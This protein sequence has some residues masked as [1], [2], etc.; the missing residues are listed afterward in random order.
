LNLNFKKHDRRKERVWPSR[1]ERRQFSD[2][3]RHI[4]EQVKELE[5][6]ILSQVLDQ[7]KAFVAT[8]MGASDPV[9]SYKKIDLVVMDEATQC[10]EPMSWIPLLMAEKAVLAGDH[11]QLPPTIKSK[12][13]WDGGLN[14]TLFE[15]IYPLIGD[16]YKTLLRIQYRMHQKIMSYSSD[17]F[18]EGKLIADP[19]VKNHTLSDLEKV[20]VDDVTKE[21]LMFLDTAGRGFEEQLEN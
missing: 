15:R 5:R 14:L 8:P 12:E 16:D 1:E 11:F 3:V 2:E 9:L 18:Y 20:Q 19:S 7:T 10:M 6:N 4:K 21:P 17:H 13:A